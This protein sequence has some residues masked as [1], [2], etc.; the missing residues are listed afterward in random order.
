[1]PP[2]T[3]GFQSHKRRLVKDMA[4]ICSHYTPFHYCGFDET[5]SRL[6][7]LAGAETSYPPYNVIA[8][9]DGRTTLEVALQDFAD[10][11]FEVTNGTKC[12]NCQ[13]KESTR[14]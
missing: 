10:S 14:R 8:G 2:L 3:S 12:S 4:Q 1:M 11:G 7:F 9:S 6:E 5:F 13:C